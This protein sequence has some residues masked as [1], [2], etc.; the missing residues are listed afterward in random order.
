[1]RVGIL[2]QRIEIE[3]TLGDCFGFGAG[4]SVDW[5]TQTLGCLSLI[6]VGSAGSLDF[7]G[8]VVT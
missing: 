8:R 4:F 3:L 7:Q 5:A 1:M 2:H 6:L